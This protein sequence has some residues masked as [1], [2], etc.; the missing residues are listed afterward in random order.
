[1]ARVVFEAVKPP[2]MPEALP[3]ASAHAAVPALA[4]PKGKNTGP[5]ASK[6]EEHTPSTSQPSLRALEQG[7]IASDTDSGTT[8]EI[9]SEEAPSS[10]SLKVRLPLGLLKHSHKTSGSS[11]K[12]KST[13]SKVRKEPEAEEG[14]ISRPTG[15][16]EA[17]LSEARFELYQKDRVEV[18]DIWVQ[19]LELNDRDDV[20][21][22][23]LD[24]S[25]IF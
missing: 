11:S 22:E 13:P 23:V 7:S 21:Q 4:G 24:S 17:D 18:R 2:V 6:P 10:G 15:P 19:I 9:I 20:T 25:L 16:S 14:K 5:E 12:S 1:M 3:L 8:E